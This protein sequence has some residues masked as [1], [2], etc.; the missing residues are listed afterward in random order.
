MLKQLHKLKRFICQLISLNLYFSTNAEILIL[1]E[2][3]PYPLNFVGSW[4]SELCEK[5]IFNE[6]QRL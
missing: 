1:S 2:I 3:H 6:S 5:G 4:K